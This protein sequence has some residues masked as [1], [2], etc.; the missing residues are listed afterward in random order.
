MV[1]WKRYVSLVWCK[2]LILYSAYSIIKSDSSLNMTD[3][4][5]AKKSSELKGKIL[6][7]V[8]KIKSSDHEKQISGKANMVNY[9]DVTQQRFF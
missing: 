5:T 2:I 9:S 7:Y 4:F 3:V 6:T 8:S 1:W